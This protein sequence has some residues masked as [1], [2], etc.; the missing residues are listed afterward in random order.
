MTTLPPMPLRFFELVPVT[1]L[2]RAFIAPSRFAPTSA[3]APQSLR[4]SMAI[5]Y[6]AFAQLA[7][8]FVAPRQTRSDAC[9][10]ILLVLLTPRGCGSSGRPRRCPHPRQR[11]RQP[12]FQAGWYAVR[13]L[14]RRCCCCEASEAQ[15]GSPPPPPP[16]PPPL[17]LLLLGACRGRHLRGRRKRCHKRASTCQAG[18]NVRVSEKYK[19]CRPCGLGKR[20]RSYRARMERVGWSLP[21][22]NS[23]VPKAFNSIFGDT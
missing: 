20:C 23:P 7:V 8:Q 5:R 17:L 9:R 11:Q 3:G 6:S 14:G 15:K 10:R 16:P 18:R 1:P 21:R 2:V 19:E 4:T 22:P 13:W 12:L